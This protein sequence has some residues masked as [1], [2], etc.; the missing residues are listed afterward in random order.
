MAQYHR[1]KR[2]HRDAILFFRLGDFYEMFFDDAELVARELDIT[3]TTRGKH[4]GEPIPMAGVP[5]HSYRPYA[6]KLLK[7]GYRIAICEQVSEP[8]GGKSIAERAVVSVLTPGTVLDETLLAETTHN[9]ITALTRLGD[10]WALASADVSTGMVRVTASPD[11]EKISEE[12]QRL[13]PSELLVDEVI[14]DHPFVGRLREA[15]SLP[16]GACLARDFE[17]DGTACA[18]ADGV[19]TGLAGRRALEGLGRYLK[20]TGGRAPEDFEAPEAYRLE[21][22]MALDPATIRNLELVET[23]RGGERRGSLL[24]AIDETSTAMGGRLLRE[25]LLRPLLDVEGIVARQERVG[26]LLSSVVPRRELRDRLK[27]VHDVPRL[28]GR[29]VTG[30]ATPRDL[31]ALRKSLQLLPEIVDRMV[32]AGLGEEMARALRGFEEL[33]AR[34]EAALVD[35][36][37][38]VLNEGGVIRDGYDETLDRLRAISRDAKGYVARLEEDERKRTGIRSLKIRYN[39]VLGYYIEVTRPNLA[40]V[41]PDYKRRQSLVNGERFATDQ[42]SE[43]EAEIHSAEERSRNL[44][45]EIFYGLRDEVAARRAGLQAAGAVLAELD[46]LVSM[47]TVAEVEGWCRPEVVDEPVLSI[48]EGRHPVVER[49]V[50]PEPFVPNSI[51]LDREGHRTLILTGPNMAGKSTFLRQVAILTLLAQTG[52][53]VPARSMRLGLVDKVFT[54]VGASD[55]LASGDSTFMVEMKETSYILRNATPASLVIL[56][57]VGRGTA[58]YDGLSLAWAIVEYLHLTPGLGPKTLFATHYHE[59]TEMANLL[60]GVANGCVLVK[61]KG[62]Q[63]VFLHRIAPG[64]ADKSYGIHVAQLAGLPRSLLD[65]ANRILLELE[66]DE[67]RDIRRKRGALSANDQGRGPSEPVQLTLFTPDHS[68]VLEEL[69]ELDTNRITPLEALNILARLKNQL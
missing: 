66:L 47:S 5:Y 64:A 61:E 1:I 37:P 60:D 48:E 46:V 3:L 50:A 18:L 24:W 52:S 14:E 36:P 59:M 58:T 54:R 53:F 12:L 38:P 65:R 56:D 68:P 4:Q 9:F 16:G 31:V 41:P 28:L 39:R 19:S 11:S 34:L 62:D 20:A 21:E 13:S 6:A 35:S 2:A 10:D 8:R 44:E 63:I 67:D 42:L 32:E 23:I 45:L 17:G 43:K 22:T 26:C 15:L 49:M 40:M 33:A 55:D 25:W 57:E 69:R 27:R 7:K 51:S 29:V 30:Q